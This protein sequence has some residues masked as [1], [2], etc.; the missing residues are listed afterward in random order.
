M[1]MRTMRRSSP[2][3]MTP[4]GRILGRST[5][6]RR[7]TRWCSGPPPTDQEV[8][9]AVVSIQEVFENHPGLDS[10]A[11]AQPLALSPISGLPPSGMFVNDFSEGSTPSEI[12]IEDSTPSDID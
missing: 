5:L 8:R 12:K 6:S 3:A 11:P 7:N 1:A 9:A 2:K 4:L 10:D